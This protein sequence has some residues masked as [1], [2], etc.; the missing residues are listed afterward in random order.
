VV[1]YP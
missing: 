1:K